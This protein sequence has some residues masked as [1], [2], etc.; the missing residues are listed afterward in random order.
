MTEGPNDQERQ[1]G[2]ASHERIAA[3]N[4]ARAVPDVERW[5]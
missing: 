5:G 2:L 1:V 4:T 3:E